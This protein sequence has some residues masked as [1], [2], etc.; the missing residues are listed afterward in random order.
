MP[1]PILDAVPELILGV[2]LEAGPDVILE[3]MP[4]SMLDAEDDMLE[5]VLDVMPGVMDVA[6]GVTEL[7][8]EDVDAGRHSSAS[9]PPT[10]IEVQLL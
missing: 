4:G 10:M 5:A 9:I 7:L 8:I 2:K 3:L 6:D 1:G